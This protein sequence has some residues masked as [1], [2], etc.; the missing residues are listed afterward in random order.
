V[1]TLIFFTP[2][3]KFHCH[4]QEVTTCKA[5]AKQSLLSLTWSAISMLLW[6]DSRF[7]KLQWCSLLF[8]VP[9][10]GPLTGK[11]NHCLNFYQDPLTTCTTLLYP[12]H[13]SRFELQKASCG[14]CLEKWSSHQY[15]QLCF[16][17]TWHMTCTRN[18][19]Q[20]GLLSGDLVRK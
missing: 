4:C 7:G 5:C 8:L 12:L 14:Q 17:M 13:T 20:V 15:V 3:I 10:W 6:Y 19:A 9:S 2:I 16:L 18:W 1:I 11:M